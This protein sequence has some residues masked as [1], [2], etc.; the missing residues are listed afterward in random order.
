[1]KKES[2]EFVQSISSSSSVVRF[3]AFIV[4]FS[5]DA[6]CEDFKFFCGTFKKNNI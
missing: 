5:L 4:G 3:R 1:M 6:E 2:N